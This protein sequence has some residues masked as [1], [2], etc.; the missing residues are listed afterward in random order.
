M[1]DVLRA[2]VR[3]KPTKRIDGQYLL[4]LTISVVLALLLGAA[5]MALCGYDPLQCYAAL[6]EGAL[7]KP[8]AVGNTLAKTATLCLCGLAV[9][10]GAKAGIFNVGGEGQLYLG[11]I[12]SAIV[13]AKLTGVSPW[14]AVPLCLLAAALAGG[15]FAYVPG[16][17][18][19]K[20]NISEV[21]TTILLNTAAISFCGFLSN[22]P[23]KSSVRPGG[24]E[25]I[26]SGMMFGK[27]IKL[28]NLN[29]S[30]FLSAGI[31]LL[32]WY[33]L[34]RSTVGFE[35]K[36]TG[37]N[38]RFARYG[39]VP[40][41]KMMIWSMVFS[42]VICGLVGMFEVFGLHG[43]FLPTI[44]NNVYFDGML[45]AMIMRYNPFGI[46]VMSFFFAMLNVGSTGMQSA[47]GI[48]SEVVF[49]V[50]SII[51]FFMAAEGGVRQRFGEAAAVRRARRE[52]R[53]QKEARV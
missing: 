53:A 1:K 37:D 8:K 27:L 48:S 33:L 35:M 20:L 49:I 11:A 16:V 26:D 12:A 31:A 45:V 23:F 28:S 2:L 17:L 4:S 9:A 36:L 39:G 38:E 32:C 22:G 46:I 15:L 41:S 40:T 14:I 52:A 13:G 51:I 50:Q 6:A 18:K 10:V 44:S 25:A 21:V 30:I 42:G 47:V 5:I 24:T 7:G 34:T 3:L 19:V 29:E 43:R